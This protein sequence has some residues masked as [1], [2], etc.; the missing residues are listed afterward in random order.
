MCALGAAML[1]NSTKLS[2]PGK[3]QHNITEHD[4]SAPLQEPSAKDP[5]AAL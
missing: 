5:A 1:H 3:Q 2:A 4:A